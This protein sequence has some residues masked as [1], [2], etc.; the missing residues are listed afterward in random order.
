[1]YITE[2]AYLLAS[3]LRD[4]V[5]TLGM[6]QECFKDT[7]YGTFHKKLDDERRSNRRLYTVHSPDIRRTDDRPIIITA[8]IKDR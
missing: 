4:S 7:A 6:Y 8:L 1:M 5:V 3:N 2:W